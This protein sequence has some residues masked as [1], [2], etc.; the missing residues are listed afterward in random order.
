YRHG[1]LDEMHAL[2]DMEKKIIKI[3]SLNALKKKESDLFK[4]IFYTAAYDFKLDPYL[5]KYITTTTFDFTK[6]EKKEVEKHLTKLLTLPTPGK[7]IFKYKNIF[8]NLFIV[9]ENGTKI[10]DYTKN[11]LSLRLFVLWQGSDIVLAEKFLREYGFSKIVKSRVLHILELQN[12]ELSLNH[13]KDIISKLSKE[14]VQTLFAYKRA[15][16]LAFHQISEIKQI[17]I[18]EA[19]MNSFYDKHYNIK[20]EHLKIKS[21][22]LKQLGYNDMQIPQVLDYLL[23]LVRNF[24][25]DNKE[26]SL[27]EAARTLFK[28]NE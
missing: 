11:D 6:L 3:Q 21:N 1:I 9:S 8:T 4:A 22:D 2:N 18:L 14:E 15:S 25:I 24:Q 13:M 26:D 17:D 5:E 27:I 19:Q 16:C 10:L 20:I 28:E 12:I 23:E 7:T